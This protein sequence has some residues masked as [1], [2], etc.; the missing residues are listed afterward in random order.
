VLETRC[1]QVLRLACEDRPVRGKELPVLSLFS[2]NP[3]PRL[4]NPYNTAQVK[5]STEH[6]RDALG[7]A[8]QYQAHVG[9]LRRLINRIVGR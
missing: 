2:A 9:P 8:S 4:D 5:Q 7:R 1:T 6:R 3:T